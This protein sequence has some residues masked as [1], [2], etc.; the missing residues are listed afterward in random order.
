MKR[1]QTLFLGIVGIIFVLFLTS[2]HLQGKTGSIGKETL[3]IFNW[4]DYMDPQLI[5]K[6]EKEY[7]YHVEY[8][9]FDSNEAMFTK[10]KQG[11]TSY[12]LAIPSDYMIQRMRTANLLLPLDH[13]KVKGMDVINPKFLN[14]SFD[15]GNNYSVP[16]F[17]GTLGI[18]YNEKMVKSPPKHWEDLWNPIYKNSILMIDGAREVMGIGLTKLGY[19]INSENQKEL[20]Q[21]LAQVEKLMPNIQAILAD[22]IKMY[23]AQNEAPLAVTY[24]GEAREMKENNPRLHYVI[25]PEGG[26]LWFD[27]LVIPITAKNINGSYDFINFMLQAENAKQNAEYVGYATPNE[28][29]QALLPKNIREDKEF[30]PDD[31]TIT[32]L[33]VYADL[34]HE[35]LEK[36]ND[37]YL[38]FKMTK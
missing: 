20:Q 13:S 38:E 36:Y 34:G 19:S 5:D 29:A 21:S 4:G 37:L 32:H 33:E 1:L 22:E 12:D 7:G 11:G 18:V 35:W 8:E 14:L 25:P 30:Y 17:W 27:N 2:L 9:T 16:Y 3:T 24:S 10:I 26:N 15:P 31:D 28:K 6:F 23:M